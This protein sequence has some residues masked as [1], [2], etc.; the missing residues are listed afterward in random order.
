[1]HKAVTEG[2]PAAKAEVFKPRSA[3]ECARRLK[4]DKPKLS[5]SEEPVT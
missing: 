3:E 2:V 5:K 4:V 1:M